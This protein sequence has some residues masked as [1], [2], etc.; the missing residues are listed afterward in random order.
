ML[1][2][3]K[4]YQVIK[5]VVCLIVLFLIL[6]PFAWMILST[7]KVQKDIIKWPPTFWPKHLI[8]QREEMFGI[9]PA[10]Q[11]KGNHWHARIGLL[12]AGLHGLIARRLFRTFW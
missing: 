6:F 9:R 3:I 11:N 8:R 12:Y 10:A 4:P 2:K 7:F 5:V 1:K